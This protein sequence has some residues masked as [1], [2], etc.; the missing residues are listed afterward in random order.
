MCSGDLD[1][2]GRCSVCM[3]GAYYRVLLLGLY[4]II[5]YFELVLI[6]ETLLFINGFNTNILSKWN[7]MYM[8][9]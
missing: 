9:M 2:D 1:D 4:R 3:T 8:Q 6:R 5:L 7:L